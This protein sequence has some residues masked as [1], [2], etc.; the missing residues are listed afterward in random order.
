MR[1]DVMTEQKRVGTKRHRHGFDT[2]ANQDDVDAKSMQNR[3]DASVSLMRKHA[4]RIDAKPLE[5]NRI[6]SCAKLYGINANRC[7]PVWIDANK[8]S[9]S[10]NAMRYQCDTNAISMRYQYEVGTIRSGMGADSMRIHAAS[11]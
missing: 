10:R 6:D 8:R 9:I 4:N 5:S 3:C 2:S 7:T 11:M 1:H